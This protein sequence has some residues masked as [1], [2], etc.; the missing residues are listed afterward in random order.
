MACIANGK[1]ILFKESKSLR[2]CNGFED[3]ISLTYY[4]QYEN[5]KSLEIV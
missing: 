3:N 2:S 4:S 1:Y 5:R